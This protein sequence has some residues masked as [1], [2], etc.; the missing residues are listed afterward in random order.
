MG[1]R[2]VA[3][4]RETGPIANCVGKDDM[5]LLQFYLYFGRREA[6]TKKGTHYKARPWGCYGSKLRR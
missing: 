2:T 1:A 3:G 5:Q 6:E 4:E